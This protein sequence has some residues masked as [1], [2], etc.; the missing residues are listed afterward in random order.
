MTFPCDTPTKAKVLQDTLSASARV[1]DIVTSRRNL[2]APTFED[3]RAS[4]F[5]L[6]DSLKWFDIAQ[7]R[8]GMVAYAQE[9]LDDGSLNFIA[10][11]LAYRT[12]ADNFETWIQA[13][14][15]GDAFSADNIGRITA[16]GLSGQERIAYRAQADLVLATLPP[17]P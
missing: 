8:P 15:P 13:N 7:A 6:H 14:W 16:R 3:V 17:K 9:E 2:S 1:R 5:A 12:A 10:E 4:W 11:A